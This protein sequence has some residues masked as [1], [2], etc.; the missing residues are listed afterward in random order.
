M[1]LW[2]IEHYND[3]FTVV[4]KTTEKDLEDAVKTENKEEYYSDYFDIK[5]KNGKRRIYSPNKLNPLYNLQYNI[6]DNFLNNIMLSDSCVGFRK[7][8][9]YFD[10]LKPH[11]CFYKDK[12][13][14][15]LDITNFFYTINYDFLREV[16]KYYFYESESLCQEKIDKLVDYCCRI[17]TFKEKVIQGAPTSPTISNIVFRQFDMR[18]EKYCNK[19]GV[20]YTRYADD[21]LFSSYNKFTISSGF[22]YTISNII[23]DG[24]FKLNHSKTIRSKDNIALNGFVI[25]NDIRISRKKRRT[26]SRIM[27]VLEN[28]Q[29]KNTEQDF[30]YLNKILHEQ[31][32]TKSISGKYTLMNYLNGYRAFLIS[33]VANI[34]S[35]RRI[36]QY[37]RYITRLESIILDVEKYKPSY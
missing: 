15:R 28:R 33:L 32:D 7:N 3:F 12:Y 25:D 37:Q 22:I 14:L 8:Y 11:R 9:S 19:V 23:N 17:L 30:N 13:Y 26:F 24:N 4:L 21:L 31:G 29:W 18:I 27:F 6:L 2:R 20:T 34:E 10:F 35:K 1:N 16:M 36:L 5:K